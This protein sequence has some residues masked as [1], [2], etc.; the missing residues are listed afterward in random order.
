MRPASWGANSN[1][2]VSAQG[3]PWFIDGTGVVV[4]TVNVKR[5]AVARLSRA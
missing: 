5:Y 3:D 2:G 1:I 4:T